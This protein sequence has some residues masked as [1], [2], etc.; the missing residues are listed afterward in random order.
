MT[1]Y[2]I[3]HPINI[4]IHL[5]EYNYKLH[6]LIIYSL[7]IPYRHYVAIMEYHV[8]YSMF[9]GIDMDMTVITV[10]GRHSR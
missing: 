4:N 2:K 1:C 6:I 5:I 10:E 3:T 7:N 8:L 9:W